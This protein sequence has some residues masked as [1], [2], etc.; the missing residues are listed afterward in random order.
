MVIRALTTLI[1]FA[2]AAALLLLVPDTGAAQGG[3]FWWRA[4]LLAAA[5]L[6]AG[7]FYQAGGVR[8]P[9]VRPNLPLLVLAFLPWTLLTVA[10]CA[11]R[12]G[13]PTFLSDLAHDIIPASMRRRWSF[14]ASVL[15][16]TSGLLLAFALFEPRVAERVIEHA[17]PVREDIEE[18][19]D[20]RPA[21]SSEEPLEL[22][23][24]PTE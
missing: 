6:V 10:I 22:A 23:G 9:G 17:T 18:N 4:A 13:T 19:L 16:F 1:G 2:C 11:Q 20:D 5:G 8:R 15:A 21:T 12:A 7:L 14:S 3:D 24:R